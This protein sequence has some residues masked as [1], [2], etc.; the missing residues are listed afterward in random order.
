MVN[1]CAL[2]EAGT[3]RRNAVRKIRLQTRDWMDGTAHLALAMPDLDETH[4]S[5][6]QLGD[7]LG[8]VNG[9]RL[10]PT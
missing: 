3:Q 9:Q 10:S 7:T 6:P 2:P 8:R 5:S 4:A 1:R